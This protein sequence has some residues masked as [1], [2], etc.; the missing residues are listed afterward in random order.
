MFPHQMEMLQDDLAEV[1]GQHD[2]LMRE[3]TDQLELLQEQ[4]NQLRK[5]V[6]G[7]LLRGWY[8]CVLKAVDTIGSYSN[9]LLA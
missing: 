1:R 2:T 4:V 3:M 6:R 8:I 5:Q 9:E 7:Q